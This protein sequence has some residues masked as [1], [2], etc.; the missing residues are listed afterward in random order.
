[1]SRLAANYSDYAELAKTQVE[2]TDYKVFVRAKASSSITVIAPHGGSIEQYTE[3]ARA[4]AGEDF[5][6]YLFEGAFGAPAT[7]R[8]SI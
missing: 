2:G 1:M 7:M 6:L 4:I 5:N 3:I 8:R